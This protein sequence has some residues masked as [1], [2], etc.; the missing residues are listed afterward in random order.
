[1][2]SVFLGSSLCGGYELLLYCSSC[3]SRVSAAHVVDTTFTSKGTITFP[4][5]LSDYK[6]VR[7]CFITSFGSLGEKV[8]N[9]LRPGAS[10]YYGVASCSSTLYLIPKL[11]FSLGNFELNCNGK[12]CSEFLR[13]FAVGATN[14]YCGRLVRGS[15]PV[16]G[17]SMSISCVVARAKVV[18]LWEELQFVPSGFGG[19]RGNMG[20]KGTSSPGGSVCFAGR[21]CSNIGASG[22]PTTGTT[23][24]TG[25]GGNNITSACYFFVVIVTISVIVSICT[26]FYL[27]SVFKV[28]GSGSSMAMDCTRR[29]SGASS[30]I[31]ILTRGRLVGY[32][33]FYG[34]CVGLTSGIIN[35]CSVRTPFRTNICCLGK[36]VNLRNVLADVVNAPRA[37]RAIGIVVPRNCAIPR[38]V[39]GLIRGRIYSGT[40]LLSIVS[41]A[42]FSCSLVS[43][44]GTGRS[45]PCELRNCLF[46]SACRFCINRDTSDIVRGFLRR[47]RGRVPRR[48]H[49]ETR[50]VNCSV[51]RVV[52]VTSVIR[53]RTNSG[54]RV[55]AVTTIVRGELR[56][57]AGCPSLNYRSAASCVGGGITPTLSS[58]STRATSCCLA[59]CDATSASAIGNLPRKPVY[60]PNGTTVRTILCP[61]SGSSCFFFRSGGNGL[62]ATGACSRFGSRVRGCTPCLDC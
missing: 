58:A 28:A 53:T 37:A 30:T 41:S 14:L 56:S 10:G 17:C 35:S 50:R 34:F 46:P 24:G 11:Y 12:C 40:T 27:G 5:Y 15:L 32:G 1:M 2:S 18:A 8:C 51:G 60:G 3:N 52:A 21:S 23:S 42:R 29:V 4:L 19:R 25:N 31:S 62:C 47:A 9:V 43:N 59:C 48:C 49:G 16:S 7:F 20:V 61:R 55:G 38:V 57:A 39:S 33:G 54:S 22:G 44:L 6:G 45:I 13:G 36:G 26:V